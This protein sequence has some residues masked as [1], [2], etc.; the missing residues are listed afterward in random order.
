MVLAST[1]GEGEPTD[2]AVAVVRYLKERTG[3]TSAGGDNS[4]GVELTNENWLVGTEYAVF[5]LGNTE[6]DHYNE[7]G[8]FFDKALGAAGAKPLLPIGLG[9]DNDD[10]EGD[11]ETWRESFWSAMRKTYAEDETHRSSRTSSITV[12]NVRR[13][14]V[15]RNIPQIRFGRHLSSRP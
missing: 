5:G 10:L 7:M 3:V 13:R 15:G 2:N 8:K 6:Y 4:E 12:P 9:N 14:T 1:Y 11:F